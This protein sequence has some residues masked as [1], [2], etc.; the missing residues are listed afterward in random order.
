[1]WC[2]L[3]DWKMRFAFHT[4]RWQ[5][6]SWTSVSCSRTLPHMDKGDEGSNSQPCDYWTARSSAWAKVAMGWGLSPWTAMS[7]IHLQLGTKKNKDSLIKT[8]LCITVYPLLLMTLWIE[9]LQRWPWSVHTACYML[10]SLFTDLK[11]QSS[12]KSYI[13]CCV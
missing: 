10:A 4:Q 7:L 5:Q 8:L 12:A 6:H 9:E 1:M 2:L 11:R 3:P 13:W